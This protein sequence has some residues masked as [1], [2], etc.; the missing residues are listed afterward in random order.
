MLIWIIISFLAIFLAFFLYKFEDLEEK[1]G[2]RGMPVII[3]F[4]ILLILFLVIAFYYNQQ[5]DSNEKSFAAVKRQQQQIDNN[6]KLV[7]KRLNEI[8]DSLKP[9]QKIQ[10]DSSMNANDKLILESLNFLKTEVNSNFKSINERLGKPLD[11]IEALN[12]SDSINLILSNQKIILEAIQKLEKEKNENTFLTKQELVDNISSVSTKPKSY[13]WVFLLS[14]I[15]LGLTMLFLFC[16]L[17]S[18]QNKTKWLKAAVASSVLSIST[19]FVFE[20]KLAFDPEFKLEL[21]NCDSSKSVTF[22][23]TATIGPFVSG[24]DILE[25]NAVWELDSLKNFFS[26]TSKQFIEIAIY[27]GVDNR[28]LRNDALLKFGDNLSLA[29]AR[30]NYIQNF[31]LQHVFSTK[32]M[33]FIPHFSVSVKG[34]NSYGSYDSASFANSRSV[35]IISKYETSN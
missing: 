29:Q 35:R 31:L 25:P 34:A 28:H 27:G 24:Y 8:S 17:F 15:F 3:V 10:L 4:N 30:A 20:G 19:K 11:T 23:D 12:Q 33:N 26:D 16:A 6:L 7:N 18:Q 14:P 2:R 22:F 21:S 1:I 13:S 32:E 9:L 5:K